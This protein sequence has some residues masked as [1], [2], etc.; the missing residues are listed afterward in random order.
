MIPAV[1]LPDVLRVITLTALGVV[2]V[3]LPTLVE[4]HSRPSRAQALVAGVLCF[5]ISGGAR[6]ADHWGEPL[7]WDRTPL[8]LTGSI[9]L[10]GFVVASWWSRKAE[11]RDTRRAR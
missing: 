5:V 4:M 9:L 1:Y 2:I 7:A 11:S 6:I 8:L 3:T 10:T